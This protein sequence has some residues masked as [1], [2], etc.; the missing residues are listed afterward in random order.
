MYRGCGFPDC[1]VRFADCEIHHV[2]E[3]IKQRGPTD[4]DNLLPLCS[5]HHHTVHDDGWTLTLHPGR[6]IELCRPDGTIH[7]N[8]PTVTV[9]PTGVASQLHELFG[10]AV[11]AAVSRRGVA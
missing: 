11:E 4:L 9:A 3:W 2:I 10:A 6:T 5:R 7:T 8:A 1:E